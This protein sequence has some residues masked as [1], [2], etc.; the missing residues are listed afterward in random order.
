VYGFRS[1]LKARFY[2]IKWI[3][4]YDP[5]CTGDV[6]RPEVCGHVRNGMG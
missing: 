1:S 5:Y 3:P 2:K 6:A 4:D